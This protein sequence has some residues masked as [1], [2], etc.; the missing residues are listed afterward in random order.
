MQ[1]KDEEENKCERKNNMQFDVE[2][3]SAGIN[4]II[5]N[6]DWGKNNLICYGA[7]EAVYIYDP[8][9][10][11]VFQCFNN[12]C[13]RINSAKWIKGRDVQKENELVSISSQGSIFIW[14]LETGKKQ[15]EH[16]HEKCISCLT[17]LYKSSEKRDAFV[18]FS[19]LSPLQGNS[20]LLVFHRKL[21]GDSFEH[22]QK[23]DLNDLLPICINATIIEKFNQILF[24]VGLSDNF[25]NLYLEDVTENKFTLAT[26]IN[27]SGWVNGIDFTF[28]NNKLMMVAACQDVAIRIWEM[29]LNVDGSN[30]HEWYLRKNFHHKENLYGHDGWTNSACFHPFDPDK[31][32]T[33]SVDKTMVYWEHSSKYHLWLDSVRVGNIGG[34]LVGFYGAV[35]SPDGNSMLGY[36]YQGAFH[37]WQFNKETNQWEAGTINSGHYAEVSDVT[38]EPKGEFILS[39][40]K[41]KTTRIHAPWIKEDEF[42]AW[43]EMARPQIHGHTLSSIT[44][45]SRYE[46]VSCAEEKVIRVFQAPK[47]FV[48]NIHRLCR[49]QNDKD[50][51]LA[52][53]NNIAASHPT[54]AMQP[55]LGLS[56]KAVFTTD[57]EVDLSA[58][59]N[60]ASNFDEPLEFV[61]QHLIRPPTE[62]NLLQNTLWPEVQKLYGHGLEV[63]CLASSPDGKFL[64]S[65]S[66]ATSPDQAYIIVWNMATLNV[67][68]RLFS[69]TLTVVQLAFSPDSQYLLSVSRDRRWS[70]FKRT[71]DEFQR[72]AT[73]Q[74]MNG[75]H[76]R[77]IFTG[78]WTRDGK[79]FATGSRDGKFVIWRINPDKVATDSLGQCEAV[80]SIQFDEKQG[81]AIHSSAF[82]PVLIRDNYLFALGTMS[83]SIMLYFWKSGSGFQKVIN[84]EDAHSKAVNKLEFR[85]LLGRASVPNT[86][87]IL[88]LASCGDNQVKI[89]NFDIEKL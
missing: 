35:F 62:E 56:N 61:P 51:D 59:K 44:S 53:Y 8:E 30:M 3:M 71:N 60:K 43:F 66:V 15:E 41:D 54:G 32:L 9:K 34:N 73:T 50:D 87:N 23:F 78:C 39:T 27:H 11:K 18:F 63:Y 84:M 29:S 26:R 25:V 57:S 48:D 17:A 24:A 40:S 12:N 72:I 4:P 20:A 36:T 74:K 89:F 28:K 49:F 83:G 69:H 38:W 33:S 77:I 19:Y 58:K 47:N 68:Q 67:S 42:V 82:A 13:G 16:F 75:I 55:S 64:A 31:M 88:Q 80:D 6:L 7:G 14:D 76:K 2:Y 85:P 86:D 22:Y 81:I 70:L 52:A 10:M 65:A 37:L 21:P 45:H 5:N 46:F 79:Y 1:P